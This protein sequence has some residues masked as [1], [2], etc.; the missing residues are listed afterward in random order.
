MFYLNIFKKTKIISMI[1]FA[2]FI[3]I[4]FNLLAFNNSMS[5]SQRVNNAISNYYYQSF[6]I[7]ANRKGIVK[8]EGQVN[9]LYDKYNIFDIASK[10]QGVKGIEDFISVN[11]Q[12][13]PA[14]II[15]DG[16]EFNLKLDKHILEPNR[17]KVMVVGNGIVILR[18]TVSYN[19]EK[20]QAE[21]VASQEKG[22]TGIVNQIKVL[23]KRIALSSKNLRVVVHDVIK[24]NFPLDKHVKFSVKK[25]VVTLDGHSHDM[26]GIDQ[27]PKDCY[28]I[29]GVKKVINDIKPI[30]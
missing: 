14:D 4:N 3:G 17:I 23:P 11:T 12:L 7:S 5:L 6:Y 2:L 21:T 26:W 29:K 25:G 1:I 16:I 24:D 30:A 10:V 28:E 8:I 15:K 20:L 9:S 27:L 19:K 22:A 18:G 13:L